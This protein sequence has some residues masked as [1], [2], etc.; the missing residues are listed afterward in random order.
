[1]ASESLPFHAH[2]LYTRSLP[3]SVSTA[4]VSPAVMVTLL[5]ITETVSAV[6]NQVSNK[7]TE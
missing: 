1:M 7:L 6:V 5:Y 2:S 4:C 3:L